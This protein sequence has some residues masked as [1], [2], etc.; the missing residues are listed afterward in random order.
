MSLRQLLAYFKT[1]LGEKEKP[2]ALSSHSA[3]AVFSLPTLPALFISHSAQLAPVAGE[4]D[5]PLEPLWQTTSGGQIEKES[6]LAV[7]CW[8]PPYLWFFVFLSNHLLSP[9]T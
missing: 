1:F 2:C 7:S 3:L 4:A 9:R 5:D 8:A 6:L